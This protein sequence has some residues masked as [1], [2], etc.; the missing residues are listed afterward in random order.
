M[1]A[2]ASEIRVR[3][4]L[5]PTADAA[6]FFDHLDDDYS[7]RKEPNTVLVAVVRA[8]GLLAADGTSMMMTMMTTSRSSDLFAA[9]IRQFELPIGRQSMDIVVRDK[10]AVGSDF[11]GQCR[12][13]LTNITKKRQWYPLA[14]KKGEPAANRGQIEI[15]VAKTYDPARTARFFSGTT[16][17]TKQNLPTEVRIAVCRACGLAAKDSMA[18]SAKRSDPYANVKFKGK[19]RRA[20][21][22]RQTLAPVWNEVVSFDYAGTSKKRMIPEIEFELVVVAQL[23]YSKMLDFDPFILPRDDDRTNESPPNEVRAA[24][25]R[26][27]DLAVKDKMSGTSDPRVMF[28]LSSGGGQHQTWSSETRKK[29]LDPVFREVYAK[30]LDWKKL[31]QNTNNQNNNNNNPVLRLTCEDVDELAGAGF[32]GQIEIPLAPIAEKKSRLLR[33]WRRDCFKAT[34]R[35]ARG[36]RRN[37]AVEDETF[38]TYYS[39]P[40]CVFTLGD[41]RWK[42]KICK[43][44]LDPSWCETFADELTSAAVDSYLGE[45][46]RSRCRRVVERVR[47]NRA[48]AYNPDLDFDHPWVI[49]EAPNGGG[50]GPRNEL[51]VGL[52]RGR[53]LAIKDK[54]VLYGTGSSDPRVRILLVDDAQRCQSKTAK[55]SL[56]PWFCH[57]K[58]MEV[59]CED[60]DDLTS[61]DFMGKIEI[62]LVFG[63][64]E[65]TSRL[66]QAPR[67]KRIVERERRAHPVLAPQPLALLFEPFMEED[68]F[69]TGKSP[70]EVTELAARCEGTDDDDVGKICI[71]LEPH[72]R[73]R[74]WFSLDSREGTSSS[75]DAS[76]LQ[77]ELILQSWFNPAHDFDPFGGEEEEEEEGEPN[78]LRIALMQGRNLAIKD[79]NLFSAITA[80]SGGTSDPLV[81]FKIGDRE[82]KSKHAAK[83]LCP[84]WHEV[85]QVP[86]S[87]PPGR[88]ENARGNELLSEGSNKVSGEIELITHFWH[89]PAIDFEAFA[90]H[91]DDDN[92]NEP[93]NEVRV[94]LVQGRRLAIK[95]KN[96]LSKGGTSDPRVRFE[97]GT[98]A[99][100]SSVEYKTLAP[101][102]RE[103][104]ALP[105]TA[106]E[107]VL[108]IYCEDVDLVSSPDL[109]GTA[110]ISLEPHKRNSGANDEVMGELE[111]VVH[112]RRNAA[113]EFA[114]FEDDLFVESLPNEL[115]V[116]LI[117]GRGVGANRVVE[118]F[119]VIG[120]DLKF[121]ES[122]VKRNEN[123]PVS[124]EIFEKP[125]TAAAAKTLECACSNATPLKRKPVVG[126]CR[127][128]VTD[129][130]PKRA[131]YSL[132]TGSS[133]ELW[134]QRR[135]NPLLDFVPFSEAAENKNKPPNEVRIGLSRGRGLAASTGTTVSS[136]NPRVTFEVGGASSARCAS[137]TKKDVLDP[138]NNAVVLRCACED[139][140][141]PPTSAVPDHIIGAVD[142]PLGTLLADGR[143]HKAWYSLGAGELEL[144]L[145]AWYNPEHDWEPFFACDEAAAAAAASINKTANEVRVG[146]SRARGLVR[147]QGRVEYGERVRATKRKSK[148]STPA[149]REC[150]AFP[151][152]AAKLELTCEDAG[153]FILGSCEIDLEPTRADQRPFK[154]WYELEPAGAVEVVVFWRYNPANDLNPFSDDDSEDAT[155]P[156]NEL[157]IGWKE[158]FQVPLTTTTTTTATC[159]QLEC[160]CENSSSGSLVGSFVVD[161]ACLAGHKVQRQWYALSDGEVEVVLQHRF[162]SIY[163]YDPFDDDNTET[164]KMPPNELR[165]ALIHSGARSRRPG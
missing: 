142:A 112:W 30:R 77:L 135:Y 78:E 69:P 29:T 120:E 143:I 13:D 43:K 33:G 25:F 75:N 73:T 31:N 151:P 2:A 156:P 103:T 51:C 110:R 55:K 99:C 94:A 152:A 98:I 146:I 10:D 6:T 53:N 34:E 122:T 17:T 95:D 106:E 134:T 18:W 127:V 15:A 125:T 3:L 133:I 119:S 35:T 72:T 165:V 40:R 5:T 87:P 28:D 64:E 26:G 100:Q 85:F 24:L 86:L 23:H 124:N 140:K 48:L 22:K 76:A 118:F 27:R 44:S 20:T 65:K 80:K 108:S 14:D 74:R 1:E 57:I 11:F 89:N 68:K 93:P 113:L 12:I 91:D 52:V 56:N 159:A 50:G 82:F 66:A 21:I 92:P 114:P 16:T 107:G 36:T 38:G 115:R 132:G 164:K 62:E 105:S 147:R 7:E 104:F 88:L 45:F 42:S 97:L 139:V 111:M 101:T 81:R 61:A 4:S 70:N 137:T 83:I 128:T 161:I 67:G 136:R 60:V 145:R 41:Q 47:R 32:M 9:T 46:E 49:E 130:T 131:W 39:D 144:V 163:A 54:A 71:S 160:V 79:K 149:W 162:N 158:V 109:I 121:F 19:T 58:I 148:T 129:R 157:R 154:Q 90:E 37:L 8:R 63:L 155:K 141:K 102:R 153:N 123:H 96:F 126:T 116:A 150:F 117:Q 59:I 84:V 138:S